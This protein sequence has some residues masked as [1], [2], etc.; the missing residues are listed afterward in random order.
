MSASSLNNLHNGTPTGHLTDD[1]M[2]QVREL[3]F[4]DYER[5]T[6]ARVGVLEN[7]IRDMELALHGR[8]D[9][10]QARLDAV[11]AEIDATQRQTLNE[12]GTGLSDL[13]DRLKRMSSD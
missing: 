12:I 4:G 8:L 10:L 11:S 7:R 2:D 6:E 3:L 13:A 1:K 9:A 5:Q